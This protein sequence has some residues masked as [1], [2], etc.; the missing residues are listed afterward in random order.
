M[1][2]G[3]QVKKKEGMTNTKK[4]VKAKKSE[5]NDVSEEKCRKRKK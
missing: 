2:K 1:T 5:R 4:S 3:K